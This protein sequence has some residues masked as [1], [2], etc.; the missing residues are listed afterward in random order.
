MSDNWL[1]LVRYDNEM[2]VPVTTY[3]GDPHYLTCKVDWLVHYLDTSVEHRVIRIAPATEDPAIGC[4]ELQ[5]AFP[6]ATVNHAVILKTGQ[7]PMLPGN[8]PVF[9][10]HVC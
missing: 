1:S 9:P 6:A 4:A 3:P 7:F 5:A 8:H 2:S 10:H